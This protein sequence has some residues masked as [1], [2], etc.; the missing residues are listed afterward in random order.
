MGANGDHDSGV[1]SDWLA[2]R[3]RSRSLACNRRPD[4]PCDTWLHSGRT[5]DSGQ[6][7]AYPWSNMGHH[8]DEIALWPRHRRTPLGVDRYP[9]TRWL[10]HRIGGRQ[11]SGWISSQA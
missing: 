2:C 9:P 10:T 3:H 6:G 8:F 7:Y 11:H 1:Q 4:R 5:M